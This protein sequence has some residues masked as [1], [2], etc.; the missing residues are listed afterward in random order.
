MLMAKPKNGVVAFVLGTRFDRFLAYPRNRYR[1]TGRTMNNLRR[2]ASCITMVVLMSSC[3]IGAAATA[4]SAATVKSKAV[5]KAAAPSVATML[6]ADGSLKTGAGTSA[7]LN[8]SGYKMELTSTGAPRFVPDATANTT[9]DDANWDDRFGQRGVVGGPLVY[10]VAV[11][12]NDVYVGGY[13]HSAA[14]M[15]SGSFNNIAHWNGRGWVAMGVG[16]GTSIQQVNG[17]AVSGSNVYVVGT[18]TTAGTV[19]ASHVAMWN[20]TAWSSM[21]GGLTY[22]TNTDSIEGDS[23]AVYGTKVVVGGVFTAAGGV[24][25]NSIAGWNGTAWSAFGSG[26]QTCVGCGSLQPGPVDALAVMGTTLYAGGNFQQAGSVVVN[27][28]ASW[29][30]SAWADVGGGVTSFGSAAQVNALAVNGTSLY[31]G[32]YFQNAGSTVANS[33]AK[34]TGSTW[35]TLS[36]GVMQ[37]GSFGTVKALLWVGNLMYIGGAFDTVGGVV[38]AHLATW[39]GTTGATV[40]D[41]NLS[42]DV[43]ALAPAPGGGVVVVGPTTVDGIVADAVAQWSGTAWSV[44]GQGTSSQFGDAGG[45]VMA[46]GATLD[47]SIYAGGG[48]GQVGGTLVSGIGRWD[49][50]TWHDV[51]GGVTSSG[52][53]ATVSSIMVNGNDV[54]V[55]GKFDAAGG[56]SAANVA[57]WNGSTWSALGS[58]VNGPVD[59]MLVANGFLYVGGNFTTVGSGVAASDVGRMNISTGVWSALGAGPQFDFNDGYGNVSALAIVG[60]QYIAVG[61]SY[62]DLG[63]NTGYAVV[64]GLTL[65]DSTSTAVNPLDGWYLG[66]GGVLAAN[67]DGAGSVTSIAVSGTTLY[68]GGQFVTAG[69]SLNGSNQVSA[70]GIAALD[71]TTQ[72]WSTLGSGLGGGTPTGVGALVLSG[73][74]LYVAG[75]FT[76]AG[77][78]SAAGVAKWST[79]T[80]TWSAFG[81]GISDPGQ[82]SGGNGG[83]AHVDSLLV[84]NGLMVAG[85]EFTSAGTHPSKDYA[86]Y[87]L[88]AVPSPG[89]LRVTTSPAVPSQITVNG[90]VTDT[91]G[92]QWVKEPAGSYTVCFSA[93]AGYTTPACQT[94]TVGSGAT[95]SVTGA[96][97]QRGYLKV[98]TSPALPSQ[99]TVDG[100]ARD[101]WGVYTD[102]PAGSHTVC[103]GA[104]AGYA[105][106]AC[107]TVNVTAGATATV[108]GTFTVSAGAHGQ[109]GMGMLRVTTSPAVASQITVDGNIT[110]TYGLNWMEIAPG[111]HVVCFTAVA[112]YTTP[113]CQ[114]VTVT[115]G[116]TTSVTG[117]FVQR[118]YLKVVT[119]PAVGG[120]VS[121]NGLPADDWGVYTDL[122]AGTYQVCFGAA[123]GKSNTPAC[124]SATVTA[125]ATVTITG[126]YS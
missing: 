10:S 8:A 24:A 52:Q 26:I 77:G 43:K 106:P 25:A 71:F 23:V 57:M 104:V 72:Q 122:P 105:P 87:T 67:N 31:V 44:Y 81:S 17:I 16:V 46:L 101:D 28:V 2:F 39:N 80:S 50:N 5:P 49:G 92:L 34:W 11:S 110:D 1:S 91:W 125:G 14:G 102:F 47:G 82:T 18:F 98:V 118:G 51:G 40:G 29:N 107:Q 54:Y 59:T 114:T 65:W 99:I 32:G 112:G 111:S 53:P 79:A 21:N 9:A 126:V 69:N 27:S 96:F 89:M 62:T 64:N 95:T 115:A 48:L 94:V 74:D 55:G 83:V 86:E 113:A 93:V 78:T 85:G 75:S 6:R 76:T 12:G 121:I 120:T 108:A 124:Q 3:V 84:G 15:Q 116:A 36:T 61:G 73:T 19:A 58:G 70:A 42:D 4:A 13:F 37:Y 45:T 38:A 30:G 88:S 103:F 123:T 109:T 56:V 97:V 100:V 33:I 68:V 7:S 35:G 20:G 63:P 66:G 119:S 90:H 41:N 117:T 60:N 22:G